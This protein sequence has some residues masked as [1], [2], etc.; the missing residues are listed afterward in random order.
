MTS[1]QFEHLPRSRPFVVCSNEQ[2]RFVLANKPLSSAKRGFFKSFN[3]EFDQPDSSGLFPKVIQDNAFNLDS[4]ILD[5][6]RPAA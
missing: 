3:I 4:S 2:N 5:Y 1:K 6:P